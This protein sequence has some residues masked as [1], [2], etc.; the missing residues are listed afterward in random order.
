MDHLL[1]MEKEKNERKKVLKNVLLSFER[2][3]ILS[4][5]L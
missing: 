2:I 4:N 1:S 5:V 3:K